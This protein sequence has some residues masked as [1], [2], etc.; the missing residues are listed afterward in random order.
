MIYPIIKAFGDEVVTGEELPGEQITDEVIQ[1]IADS[2]ALIG[3]LT[4]RGN[5]DAGGVWKTHRWVIEEITTAINNK[6]K[7]VEVRETGVDEQG[8]IVGDRQHIIYD[9][10]AR[11]KCIVEI[12]KTIGK[13]HSIE[14][15]K[16]KLLPEDCIQ[17][18]FPLLRNADLRCTYKIMT[19]DGEERA[20]SV[21]KVV[22]INPGGLFLQ[23]M[24]PASHLYKCTLN[25]RGS[26][27]SQV[28]RLQIPS[29]FI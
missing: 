8:G 29:A 17:E 13:W 2:D 10:S 22:S 7:I 19:E 24:C 16:L 11:D 25:I 5:P 12:I 18:I 20:E 21:T 9:E 4:R 26:T 23:K 6:K 1:K 14:R 28:M 3:F 27:G 15:I